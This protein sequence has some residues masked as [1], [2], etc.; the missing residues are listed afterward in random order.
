MAEDSGN[1]WKG[2]VN[3]PLNSQS[4]QAIKANT[5]K[6]TE[7]FKWLADM[8]QAGYKVGLSWDGDRDCFLCALTGRGG[9]NDGMTMTQRHANILVA[10]TA[11][12]FAHETLTEGDWENAPTQTMFDW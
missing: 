12:K 1:G 5:L 4:K 10:I 6:N 3:I 9:V 11:C 8:A 2:F 7:A